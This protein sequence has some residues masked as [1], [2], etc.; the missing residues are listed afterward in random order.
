[1]ISNVGNVSSDTIKKYVET[2]KTRY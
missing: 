2:Q 1:L